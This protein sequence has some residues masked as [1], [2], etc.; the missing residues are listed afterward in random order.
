MKLSLENYKY[1]AGLV[2]M[3]E[4]VIERNIVRFLVLVFLLHWH[5]QISSESQVAKSLYE[6]LERLWKLFLIL[7]P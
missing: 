1:T 4:S 2:N 5:H 3:Y 7:N 6:L